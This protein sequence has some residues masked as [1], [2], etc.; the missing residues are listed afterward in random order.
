MNYCDVAGHLGPK[1]EDD[2]H[3]RTH[4]IQE[5]GC[6]NVV[7]GG[8][9]QANFIQFRSLKTKQEFIFCSKHLCSCRSAYSKRWEACSHRLRK[10]KLPTRK[11]C[12]EK[13]RKLLVVSCDFR[14]WGFFLSGFRVA[15]Q[16]MSEVAQCSK[17][18]ASERSSFT[19]LIHSFTGRYWTE[20]KKCSGLFGGFLK[21]GYPQIIHFYSILIGFSL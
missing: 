6:M 17:V 20:I 3:T 5:N 7:V 9:N 12:P 1:L 21:W 10:L 15:W 13:R 8:T 19:G 18:R 11:F 16:V 2:Q 14:I 4:K